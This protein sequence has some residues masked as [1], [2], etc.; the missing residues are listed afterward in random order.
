MIEGLVIPDGWMLDKVE[1]DKIIL[2][3]D[4]RPKTWEQ[5][6]NEVFR[7]HKLSYIS[8]F[9]V[10]YPETNYKSDRKYGVFPSEYG[11]AVRNLLKLL[12]CYK[13][14]IGNWKPAMNGSTYFVIVTDYGK[15]AKKHYVSANAILS[16]PTEEMRDSFYVTFHPLIEQSKSLL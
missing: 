2:K 5:C 8:E 12:V 16:F 15:L 6:Y 7:E 14:W 9:G 3:K 1:D 11:N 10:I 4:N 13:A